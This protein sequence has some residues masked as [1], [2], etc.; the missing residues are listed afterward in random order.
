MID[1]FAKPNKRS[2][3]WAE[4]KLLVLDCDG[5]MTDGRIIYGN[6]GQEIKNFSA[7]DGLG[8][9]L[10]QAT[11]IEVAVI[12]G[13][14][15][16]ALERRCKD[17]KIE[18]LYQGV[19]K[20]LPQLESLLEELSLDFDN[21]AFIGDDWND[22]LCMRKAAISACP[23]DAMPEIARLAD[24]QCQRRGG[25]GA[26][27]EFIEYILKRKGIFERVVKQFMGVGNGI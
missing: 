24:Y 8:L 25:F 2:V 6:Q 4:I 17:L 15:S 11:N 21:V 5:V 20:K 14:S 16:E 3:N 12:T 10:L 1:Y 26:V 22:M 7:T 9:M 19:A 23:Q 27:R 18:H 13:R